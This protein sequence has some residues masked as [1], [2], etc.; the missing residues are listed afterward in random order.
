MIRTLIQYQLR[1]SIPSFAGSFILTFFT[2]SLASLILIQEWME[3]IPSTIPIP[4]DILLLVLLPYFCG[5]YGGREYWS[6][7]TTRRDPF[8]HQ[9]SYIRTLP[10]S[11]E[12][13]I[14]ARFAILFVSVPILWTLFFGWNYMVL[15]I[16]GVHVPLF[17]YLSLS[18]IWLGYTI[19]LGGGFP[20]LEWSTSGKTFFWTPGLLLFLIVLITFYLNISLKFNLFRWTWSLAQEVGPLAALISL[21]LGSLSL[22]GWYRLTLRRVK[23]RDL[24][25]I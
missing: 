10:I 25:L 13:F 14:S 23:K 12:Q 20:F 21:L 8:S 19:A 24:S 22:Y 6:F 17:D 2:A 3:H 9:L 7:T 11:V 4:M 18:F 5:V 16:A 1:R 15:L